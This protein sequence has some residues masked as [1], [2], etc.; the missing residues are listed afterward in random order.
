MTPDEF[1]IL[2]TF[3][4]VGDGHQLYVQDW[5]N[6]H[7][8]TPI[9]YLHGG[10]G[11]GSKNR[12]RSRFNPYEQR[13]IF[14]DQRG[15][16]RSLPYGSLENNTTDKLIDD[17]EKIASHL[18]I[19][20]FSLTGNSWGTCLALAYALKYPHRVKTMALQ[21]IFTGSQA[22]MDYMDEGGFRTFFPDSWENYVNQTPESHRAHPTKYH[23]SRI[24]G[25]DPL[26]ARES[27]YIYENLEASLVS[28]DDRFTPGNPD[29]FD[30]N[31]IR[32]EAHYMSNGCFMDDRY[33]LDNVHNLNMPIWLVQGRYDVICPPQTAYGVHKKALNS[34]LIWTVAGHA[35][36]RSSYDVMRT[37]LATWN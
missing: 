8:T 6:P 12:H 16:G 4:D 5:G 30:P 37:I 34:T 15:C 33:I 22:E 20:N 32:I 17:I 29:E 28:L 31:G 27:A 7:A 25:N 36:D 35:N 21:G 10:P 11:R 24:L 14:F 18:K 1:T 9:I 23:F 26:A 2:E 19:D 3:L 13:V